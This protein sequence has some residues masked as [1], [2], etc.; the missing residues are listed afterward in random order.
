VAEDD[1]DREFV[2]PVGIPGAQVRIGYSRDGGEVTAFVVQLEAHLDV[3]GA[4]GDAGEWVEVVRSDHHSTAA[5]GH[6]VTREGIHL[7]VYRGGEKDHSEHLTGP[8]PADIGFTE[9]EER[10]TDHAERYVE[11][12]REWHRNNRN[13][14]GRPNG[15]SR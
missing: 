5:G 15:P 11:R 14:S 12:Y 6:D 13:G 10:I 1:Y 2:K 9:A 7:D 8:L 4:A 3:D